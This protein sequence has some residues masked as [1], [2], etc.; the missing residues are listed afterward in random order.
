MTEALERS[1]DDRQGASI[2]ETVVAMMVLTISVLGMAGGAVVSTRQLLT[3]ELKSERATV[4]QSTLERLR[5]LPFDSV[6]DGSDELGAF[7]LE[8]IVTEGGSGSKLITLTTRGPGIQTG[9]D[10]MA[11]QVKPNVSDSFHYRIIQP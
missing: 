8:W 7:S 9:T 1:R 3:A 11:P 5:A 2:V 4:R 6:A 10:A